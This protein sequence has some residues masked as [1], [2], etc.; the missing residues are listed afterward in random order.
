MR[1]ELDINK[2]SGFCQEAIQKLPLKDVDRHGVSFGGWRVDHF[3]QLVPPG[4]LQT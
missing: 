1:Q 3:C 2:T 4:S